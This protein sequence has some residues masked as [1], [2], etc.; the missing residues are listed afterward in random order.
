MDIFI[1]YSLYVQHMYSN[2]L[3]QYKMQNFKMMDAK[4]DN[5]TKTHLRS[6]GLSVELKIVQKPGR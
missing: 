1:I 4:T 6:Q 3:Q 5:V 2:C